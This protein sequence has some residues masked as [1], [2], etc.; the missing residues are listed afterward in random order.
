VDRL[1]DG[2]PPARIA[3]SG[4]AEGLVV[5][6]EGKGAAWPP[7]LT[8]MVADGEVA[9]LLDQGPRRVLTP[10]LGRL[11]AAAQW[12]ILTVLAP[13]D[14]TYKAELADTRATIARRA[15]ENYAAGSAAI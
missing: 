7:G 5:L 4:G 15:Q 13:Q 12:Q 11:A 10:L 9:C 3:L 2:H 1:R 8:A 14:A 6:P